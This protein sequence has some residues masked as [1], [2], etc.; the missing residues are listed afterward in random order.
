MEQFDAAALVEVRLVTG[1]RNQIRVQAS[2]RQHPL[3]GERIYRSRTSS[4]ESGVRSPACAPGATAGKPRPD[5]RTRSERGPSHSEIEFPRQA[6][7]AARLAVRHPQTGARVEFRAPLP[8]DLHQ[9][10]ARLR[11]KR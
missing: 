4:P 2:L 8:S 1:K 11:R 3:V 6:L 5:V 9:L 7:H 10:M